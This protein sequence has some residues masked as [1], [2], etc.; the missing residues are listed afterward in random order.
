MVNQILSLAAT[1]THDSTS[2]TGSTVSQPAARD[3]AAA[4]AAGRFFPPFLHTIPP[5]DHRLREH[6]VTVLDFS[7]GC[8]RN[9]PAAYRG[10]ARAA[11]PSTQNQRPLPT[12][13][14]AHTPPMEPDLLPF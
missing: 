7:S 3:T 4:A 13:H 1:A 5:P 9:L 12:G 14:D 10:L 11:T 8:F 6:S 2:G